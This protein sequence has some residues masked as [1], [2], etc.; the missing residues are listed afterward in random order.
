MLSK[1][2]KD[3]WIT[4]LR[5]GEY[6]QTIGRLF[7]GKGYCCIGVFCKAVEG[8]NIPRTS[9]EDGEEN[10]P[11]YNRVRKLIGKGFMY[12]LINMNDD[13]YSFHDIAEKIE[14]E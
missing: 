2:Q 8:I 11:H 14:S 7:S 9:I 3:K 13:G 4:A 5:S 12:E 6:K 1:E 10:E